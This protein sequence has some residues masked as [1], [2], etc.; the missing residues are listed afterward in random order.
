MLKKYQFV[1]DGQLERIL[2]EKHFIFLIHPDA[3]PI[4]TASYRAGSRQRVFR[5]G[6]VV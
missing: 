5:K 2:V 1:C 6:K 4:H 3:V